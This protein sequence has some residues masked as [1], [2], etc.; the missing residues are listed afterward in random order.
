VVVEEAGFHQRPA[1]AGAREVKQASAALVALLKSSTQ[2]IM[3]DLYT[4]TLLGGTQSLYSGGATAI[5]DQATGRVFALGPRFERSTTRVLIG[6]QSDELDLRVYPAS[7]DLLG[8]TSWEQAA[9]QG[10]LDGATVQLERAFMGAAGAGYGDTSAGTVVLF[11]GRL[12]DLEASRTMI[13]LKVRSHLDL[14][15]IEMPRRLWQPSC[16]HNFGDAMCGYDRINGKNADG[17]ATGI[18][19]LTFA[20]AAGSSTI[21]INGAPSTTSPFTLGT[22]VGV[23]GANAGQR[24]TIAGFV[25]G[26][27]VSVKLAFLSVPAAGDTFQILPGCDRTLATCGNT[28]RNSR[29]TSSGYNPANAERF[30]G[31]PFVPP[32]ENAI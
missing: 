20:S 18:G 6:I 12:S 2:F 27:Y 24:R 10:Q 29:V 14:L 8:G 28:F 4:F 26:N 9:W 15:N 11:A 3:A 21:Q 16:N 5:T 17:T 1:I 30:G 22:I 25:S 7:T 32:A 31:M 23:T 19:A 13:A